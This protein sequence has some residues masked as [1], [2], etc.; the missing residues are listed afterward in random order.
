V[1][2]KLITPE[3]HSAARYLRALAA[4]PKLTR[5]AVFQV[6][7]ELG[8]EYPGGAAADVVKNAEADAGD[9]TRVAIRLLARAIESGEAKLPA[10]A[11]AAKVTAA[12]LKA[13]KVSE[14][15]PR[16]A[17]PYPKV[18]ERALDEPDFDDD[19]RGGLPPAEELED[20]ELLR[21]LADNLGDSR[22][23]LHRAAVARLYDIAEH[24]ERLEADD[25]RISKLESA[26]LVLLPQYVELEAR[27][28]SLETNVNDGADVIQGHEQEIANLVV[29]TNTMAD[30]IENLNART[31]THEE[32]VTIRAGLA[33]E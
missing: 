14:E 5:E 21:A 15:V 13:I 19:D 6:L 30:V 26:M 27:L 8:F 33:G 11:P 17:A 28:R 3:I 16:E 7:D 29:G 2:A 9:A 1:T 32:V 20:G 18:D 24:L 10:A 22:H 12:E 23:P 4:T 31:L 25:D